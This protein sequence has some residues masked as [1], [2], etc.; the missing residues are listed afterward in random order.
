MGYLQIGHEKGG[1]PMRAIGGDGM[2]HRRRQ[3]WTLDG[4]DRA[5]G[6]QAS[7]NEHPEEDLA[8]FIF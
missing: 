4:Q 6:Q 3:G 2:Y 1:E 8:D 7:F 5:F